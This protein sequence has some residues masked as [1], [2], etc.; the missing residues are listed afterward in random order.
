M[1][2]VALTAGCD[3]YPPTEPPGGQ[4]VEVPRLDG[5]RAD[6]HVVWR[7]DGFRLAATVEVA[8]EEAP[9]ALHL[10]VRTPSS[11]SQRIVSGG[12][13]A[14]QVPLRDDGLAG[15]D[16]AGDGVFT[17]P[18][19][20]PED[21]DAPPIANFFP[22]LVP[23]WTWEF[24][25]TTVVVALPNDGRLRID[26]YDADP[27]VVPVPHVVDVTEGVQRTPHVVALAMPPASDTFPSESRA[28]LPLSARYYEVV[29]HD[30]DLLAT[31]Q[32]DI[33]ATAGPAGVYYPVQNDVV[34]LGQSM[35]DRTADF[36]SPGGLQGVILIRGGINPVSSGLIIHEIAHRWFAFLDP[37]LG[38]SQDAHWLSSLDRSYNAFQQGRFNDFELYLMGLLPPDSVLPPRLGTT[39]TT[40]DDVIARHGARAPAW[41]EAQSAFTMATVVVLDRT[42]T[43]EELALF[44]FLTAELGQETADPRRVDG[45]VRSFEQATAGR[46]TLDTRIP[47]DPP[48]QSGGAP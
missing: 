14:T 33:R 9:A 43:V 20:V 10:Y 22:L 30:P 28:S 4:T 37:E 18:M 21:S 1:L 6:R 17:S 25:D 7:G 32:L 12:A 29:G 41:P 31:Y 35:I 48:T 34:G 2:L 13:E 24:E 3:I 38:L 26:V 44:D 19:L 36:G 45:R 8:G 39:G 40:I 16:V 47:D 46:A 11:S 27:A 23:G 5:L 42:L 15:D